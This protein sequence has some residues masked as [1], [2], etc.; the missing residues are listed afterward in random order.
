MEVRRMRVSFARRLLF[1]LASATGAL[2]ALAAAETVNCTAITAA[3]ATISASGL[4][5]LTDDLT[6]NLASGNAIQITANNVVLDL[7]GH[8]L[9]N[10][11]GPATFAAGVYASGN[12]NVTV[13]N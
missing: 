2:P 8:R 1:V 9:S 13:K 10:S 4:Y 3:P 12:Q 5:C 11:G 7:N 6:V